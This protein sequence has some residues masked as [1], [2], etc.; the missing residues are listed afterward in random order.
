ME[1]QVSVAQPGINDLLA[2]GIAAARAGYRKR[3]HQ[4]LTQLVN[5][6]PEQERAWLWLSFVAPSPRQARAYLR[7]VLRINPHNRR[8]VG[9]LRQIDARLQQDHVRPEKEDAS[10]RL[11]DTST[12]QAVA[13]TTAP[14]PLGKD[15]TRVLRRWAGIWLLVAASVVILG[16]FVTQAWVAR[17]EGASLLTL[18]PTLTPSPSSTV[19]PTL[20]PTPGIPQR[21]AEH[22]PDLE[23]A[24]ESRNWGAAIALLDQIAR[25]DRTYP[26]LETAKCDTYLHW[27]RDQ[28]N[29]GQ[30][31]QAYL[32]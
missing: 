7:Q 3:A 9:T 16:G 18:G 8:A 5:Q 10:S 13:P 17:R 32:L 20:T 23:Q 30:I 1:N 26:G 21:V 24:W 31:E 4:L 27:A 19:P 28:A 22:V 11:P 15:S 25:L 12:R 2:Q 6:H 14:F 29:Q